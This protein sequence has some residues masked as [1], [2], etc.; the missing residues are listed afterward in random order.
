MLPLMSLSATLTRNGT[1]IYDDILRPALD[2]ELNYHYGTTVDSVK[3][4]DELTIT[5]DAPPQTA[6]HEGYEMAFFEMPKLRL[7]L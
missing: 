5:V 6:R 4:D 1:T 3:S 7:T 2:S